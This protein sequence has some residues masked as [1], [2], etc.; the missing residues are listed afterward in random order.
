LPLAWLDLTHLDEA[1]QQ[2]QLA[3]ATID[4]HATLDLQH[5]PLWRVVYIVLGSGRGG[6]LLFVVHHLAIDGVSWRPLLED[7]ETAYLQLEA[8]QVP[9]LPPRTSSYKTWA[10]RLR[11][12]AST[13]ALRDELAH[14][15]A[16][17]PPGAVL[18]GAAR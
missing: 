17:V 18:D 15:N 4:A 6:R 14:W 16:V 13:D 2:R 11:D 10:G 1:G 7:L 12:L 5:G 8:G 3:T 9:Q